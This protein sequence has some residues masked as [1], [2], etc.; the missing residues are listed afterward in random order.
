MWQVSLDFYLLQFY[1]V[2]LFPSGTEMD[3]HTV[4]LS[5]LSFS[6]LSLSP[7]FVVILP[8][9]LAPLNAALV[10]SQYVV[11]RASI[12][13]TDSAKVSNLKGIPIWNN[14]D[15]KKD[16]DSIWPVNRR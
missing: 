15:E 1:M 4:F 5:W 10:K 2:T 11:I 9:T 16:S 13:H 7:L 3:L 12:N 6:F 14:A 8:L